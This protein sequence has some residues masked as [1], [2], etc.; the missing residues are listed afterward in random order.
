MAARVNGRGELADDGWEGF[1]VESDWMRFFVGWGD[2]DDDVVGGLEG[3]TLEGFTA[4]ED[5]FFSF[6]FAPSA[7]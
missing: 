3:F 1:A 4:A 6:A 2:D 5:N 7:R